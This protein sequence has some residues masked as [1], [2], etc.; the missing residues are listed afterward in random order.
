MFN[1]QARYL[2]FLELCRKQGLAAT[3]WFTLGRIVYKA[4]EVVPV[5]KDLRTLQPVARPE[6]AVEIV[7]VTAERLRGDALVFLVRSRRELVGRYLRDGHLAFALV[8]NGEV[9][10]EVCC[11]PQRAGHRRVFH[12]HLPWLRIRLEDNEV[13]ML[14]LH[15]VPEA[16]GNTLAQYFLTGV[17][18]ELARRGF[19][20]A[21]GAFS[22]S[23][24]PA[25]WM[26]RL[27]GFQERPRLICRRFFFRQTSRMK[28][29][30]KRPPA[31]RAGA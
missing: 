14:N 1:W 3:C 4:D 25:L 8:R 21:Y 23:N 20:K 10:G 7:E 18:E 19:V 31:L 17:L 16:R 6:A 26:N 12:P 29:A 2:Q 22:A 27:A 30:T 28:K 24:I 13:F 9:I 15:I 5:E 11:V